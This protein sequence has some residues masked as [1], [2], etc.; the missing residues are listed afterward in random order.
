MEDISILV[1]GH[2]IPQPNATG[3]GVR[4]VQLLELCR[5]LGSVHF[6][7]TESEDRAGLLTQMNI[8]YTQITL[9]SDSFNDFVRELNPTVVIFDRFMTE[10]QYSWR[11]REQCPNAIRILDTEDL[12]FLREERSKTGNIK[13]SGKLSDT[14]KR[15]LA[16]IFRSDI[17][18]MIS[19]V[20]TK[21]LETLY[22]VPSSQLLYLPF[23]IK[24]LPD[25]KALPEFDKRADF[26]FIG[27]G[28]HKP[29]VAAIQKLKT[30]W[31]D[32]KKAVPNAKLHIYGAYLPEFV[33]QMHA[34]K[35]DFLVHGFVKEINHT[36]IQHRV[37]L[38]PL[39]FGAGQKRKV[40][41][42]WLSGCVVVTSVIGAEG[43]ANSKIFGEGIYK[44]DKHFIT[45]AE[46][47]YNDQGRWQEAQKISQQFLQNTFSWKDY[48]ALFNQCV[49]SRIKSP[50]NYRAHQTVSQLL[51]HHS[52]QST[53]YLSKWIQEKNK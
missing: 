46:Q 10:E 44:D 38:A 13:P 29:N 43:I 40:L 1:I 52:Q 23:L 30:L 19:E 20:E 53:K 41:D 39:D 34:P 37:L 12:H 24:N 35:N 6:C 49:T 18:L 15:E 4:M 9:N 45:L 48:A 3:A 16:A 21:Y 7:S 22:A 33:M 31:P 36:L 2:G 14:A 27:N 26:C 28:M 50:E 42:A 11:V 51:W 5:D 47:F 8:Q 17:S 25:F 32:L